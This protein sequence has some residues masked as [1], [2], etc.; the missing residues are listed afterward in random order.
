MIR[1]SILIEDTGR[2]FG[3]I[4]NELVEAEFGSGFNSAKTKLYRELTFDFGHGTR[5]VRT[6]DNA[7]STLGMTVKTHKTKGNVVPRALHSSVGSP[8]KPLMRYLSSCLRQTVKGQAH[9]LQDSVDLANRL[10][11]LNVRS[12]H[13][14]MK[15]DVQDYFMSGE[16]PV[17]PGK[18]SPHV[19]PHR[20]VAF[21]KALKFVVE[22]QFVESEANA[23]EIYKVLVGAGMGLEMSGDVCDVAFYD[24]VERGFVDSSEFRSV[25]RVLFYVRFRDD[26]LVIL[27]GTPDTRK[28][29]SDEMKTRSSFF[30]LKIE[31]I[32]PSSAVMLDLHISK[33]SQYERTGRLDVGMHFK[34]TNQGSALSSKSMHLPSTHMS[35]PQSRV[36]H[37]FKCCSCC[38]LFRSA[39][40][41]LF[42]KIRISDVGHPALVAIAS[43]IVH[44]TP[45]GNSNMYGNSRDRYSK[46]S[47]IIV[48]YH[49]TWSS[50]DRVLSSFSDRFVAEGFSEHVPRISW[51]KAGPNLHNRV[52]ADTR[53]K[54]NLS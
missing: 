46:C 36:L 17:L 39:C 43:C 8:L 24:M 1:S 19:L 20:R 15:I 53:E 35:W 42:H 10:K 41:K 38:R 5:N 29:F 54:L 11:K 47:R 51:C 9:L 40:A 44:G 21:E 50:L 12:W 18:T 49:P 28:A 34:D 27:G 45:T 22:N 13:K 31:S 4:I 52:L 7:V 32:S 30:K 3:N 26:I 6:L 16:H 48:P 37:Y 25:Y 2:E 33:G 14:F 23:L